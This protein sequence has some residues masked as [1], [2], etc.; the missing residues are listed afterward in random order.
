V[1]STRRIIEDDCRALAPSPIQSE[2]LLPEAHATNRWSAR[3]LR[4]RPA[5]WTAGTVLALLLSIRLVTAAIGWATHSSCAPDCLP[6]RIPPKALF[7]NEVLEGKQA[8]DARIQ[9]EELYREKDQA[10]SDLYK[11]TSEAERL[12]AI[13]R[14]DAAIKKIRAWERRLAPRHTGLVK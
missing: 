4:H 9:I 13:K 1:P 2:R 6:P 10:R 5:L 8:E 12:A 14:H 3:F 11:A 7:D